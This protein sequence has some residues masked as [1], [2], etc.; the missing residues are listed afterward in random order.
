MGKFSGTYGLHMDPRPIRQK[1]SPL[2]LEAL[3]QIHTRLTIRINGQVLAALERR[4]WVRCD[5]DT[6]RWV[7]T[8]A[9]LERLKLI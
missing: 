4:K 1:A 6:G 8:E 7:V 5:R 3:R 2:M 9:G